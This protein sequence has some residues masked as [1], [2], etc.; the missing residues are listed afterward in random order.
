[1]YQPRPRASGYN[2]PMTISAVALALLLSAAGQPA[3][4]AGAP[5][6][7]PAG[8]LAPEIAK[9]MMESIVAVNKA[10][11]L[12]SWPSQGAVPCVD[13]GGQGVT[14]KDVSAADARKCATTALGQTFPELGKSFVL[15][16]LMASIGPV[17]VIALGTGDNTGWG[18][19]SCDPG[20]TCKPMKMNPGNKWGKRLLERQA[21]ACGDTATLWFPADKRACPA[22]A[23]K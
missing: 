11:G 20:R 3:T 18:A 8:K 22:A 17:T 15:A 9:E 5:A 10:L 23:A 2:A 21:R 7:A 13:R 6:G 1:M 12:E 4:G 16:V 19:Y 14:A